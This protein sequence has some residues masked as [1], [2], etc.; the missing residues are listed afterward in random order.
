MFD[1]WPEGD[2]GD[3]VWIPAMAEKPG[4][5]IVLS[6]DRRITKNPLRQRALREAG[7]TAFF[8]PSGFPEDDRIAQC[9][10]L[11]QAFPAIIA[12]AEK[13]KRGEGFRLKQNRKIERI[14]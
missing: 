7:L 9:A 11:F 5:W 13:A 14:P 1:L 12:Q 3:L 2:P 10:W 4:N 8:M 6:G